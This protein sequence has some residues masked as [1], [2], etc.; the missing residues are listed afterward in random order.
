[1]QSE[2]GLADSS[3]PDL[4]SQLQQLP[5]LSVNGNGMVS[6]VVQYRGLFGDRLK[7]KVDDITIAGA[8]PNAM[9]S[10]LSHVL[11][12]RQQVI[13]HQGV[14]AVSIAPET[15]GGAVEIRDIAPQ[16]SSSSNYRMSSNLSA[17]YFINNEA[18]MLGADVNAANNNTYFTFQG[19]YQDADNYESGS[20]TEVPSTFYERSGLKFGAGYHDN[21]N[22]LDF[23][24]GHRNTNESGTPAL[25]MDIIFIDSLWYK[26]SYATDIADAFRVK[27]KVYGNQNEH[28]MNNYQLRNPPM[29]AMHRLNTVD[30]EALGF[31][32]DF[33]EL[34]QADNSL[35]S[36]GLTFGGS[37]YEQSHN[38]RI[39][40][41][42]NAMF[43]IQ[44]FNDAQRSIA[45]L[46]AEQ[47]FDR[48]AESS[49]LWQVGGRLSRVDMQ[50]DEVGSN[51]VM[52]NPAVATLVNGFN[53]SKR[54]I[55]YT[56]MDLVV[57][58][59]LPLNDS[60]VGTFSAGHKERAPSYTEVFSWFPLGV[61]GG[62]ADGRNYI[63]SLELDKE[64]SLQADIGFQ[65]QN[66]GTSLIANVFYQK[67]D[68]YIIGVP[69][70]DMAANMIATMMGAQQP[71][72]WDNRAARL[73]GVDAYFSQIL[74]PALQFN[75]SAQYVDGK[76]TD[77][78]EGQE[79][80]LY[81]V[82]PLSANL[83]LNW[84][85]NDWDVALA[86]IVAASQ[87]KVSPLQNEAETAGYGV[88]N[89][90]VD[91]AVSSMMSVS[92]IVENLFDKEYATHLGGINRT[93]GNDVAVGQK[94][95]EAGRNIGLYLDYRF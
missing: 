49:I 26:L 59:Q 35:S 39:T 51:M 25:A 84:Q 73:F 17:N 8:G 23:V 13:L 24:V 70:N 42:N 40:N 20:G 7:I 92:F 77:G 83:A 18:Q 4:R 15:L 67:I 2:I 10:P 89:V 93:R 6:G 52:M 22:E 19:Q 48:S 76:L 85:H 37:Y 64:S 46:Y 81:R 53:E 78:I 3:S 72:Q 86:L 5:G 60:L 74:S 28:A 27:A 30:S 14:A 55:D 80:D 79:L 95:P 32:V 61:S 82:A 88:W 34:S 12:K 91:Y 71:L 90:N 11:G 43:F 75:A 62:L 45:S 16:F 65:Y 41:P 29:A 50:A 63:G 87:D 33:S 66:N 58:A 38:S 68:D 31:D 9:D 44:N 57:K 1:M 54:K 56:L 69:S 47:E 21:G 36:E 94:V